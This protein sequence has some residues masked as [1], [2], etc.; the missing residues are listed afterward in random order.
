VNAD[1]SNEEATAM[2]N[3][4]SRIPIDVIFVPSSSFVE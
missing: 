2:S 4:S 1:R 3:T